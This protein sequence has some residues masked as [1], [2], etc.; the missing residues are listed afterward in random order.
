MAK[1]IAAIIGGFILWSALWLAYNVILQKA[2]LLP[3]DVTQ[4]VERMPALLGGSI[5]ISLVTGW[6]AAMLRVCHAHQ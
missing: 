2:G 4:P 5:V 1:H 3:G 6:V